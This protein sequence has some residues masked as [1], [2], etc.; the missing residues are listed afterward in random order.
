M[1]L[2]VLVEYPCASVRPGPCPYPCFLCSCLPAVPVVP[3]S[4]A[5][6]H[7]AVGRAAGIPVRMVGVPM[8][9]LTKVGDEDSP[10]E[11]FVDCFNRRTLLRSEC[12]DMIRSGRLGL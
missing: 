6:I 11:L 7:A 10:Q 2:P 8:H 9:F 3:T 4:L 12:I 1:I 5:V